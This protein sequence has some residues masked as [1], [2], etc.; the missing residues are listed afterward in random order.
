MTAPATGK[1]LRVVRV[2]PDDQPDTELGT[3]RLV[4]GQLVFDP[5]EHQVLVRRWRIS[6]VPD[7]QIFAELADGG[8]SNGYTAIRP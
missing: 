8:W 5:E 3:V 1:T 2:H 4:D 6:N 7:D